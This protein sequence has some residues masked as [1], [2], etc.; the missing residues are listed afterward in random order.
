M[1]LYEQISQRIKTKIENEPIR[2]GQKLPSVSQFVKEW[3]VNP[4]TVLSALE[5]LE[6][7]GVIR[8]EP[9]KRAVVAE[10]NVTLNKHSLL[11]VRWWGDPFCTNLIDGLQQFLRQVEQEAVIIDACCNHE[12]V[13]NVITHPPEGTQGLILMPFETPEYR[14][15]VLEA[16]KKGLKVVFVDR[17]LPEVTASAVVSDHFTGGYQATTHL[18]ERHNRPVFYV[19]N[20]TPSS[21][22]EWVRGW[23]MAMQE[24]NFLDFDAY[25][26][27]LS[28]PESETAQKP[29]SNWFYPKKKALELFETR[30]QEKYSIFAGSDYVARGIYM[31]AEEKG[32]KVGQDVFIVG[33]DDTPFAA[34]LPVPLSSVYQS[35]RQVGY[36]AG[37][38]LY[39]EL[40]GAVHRPICR[41]IPVELKIRQSST[42]S[43]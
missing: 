39:Q 9:R 8:C 23:R 30:R 17:I 41:V 26:I 18:I 28:S 15:A 34:K 37:K 4:R 32:L 7:D 25:Q 13:I 6:K 22:R 29:E 16:Q 24:H 12:N 36:E 10:N 27:D 11:F 20:L 1:L 19:G 43:Y 3:N 14:E 31:A 21:C 40:T 38:L 5:L 2:P 35:T 42:G 33:F